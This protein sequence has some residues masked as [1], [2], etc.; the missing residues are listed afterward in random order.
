MKVLITGGMGFIGSYLTEKY[1]KTGHSVYI[2]DD[3]STGSRKNIEYLEKENKYSELLFLYE[4]TILNEK[5]ILELIGTC[6][7]VI[8]LAAAVGVKYILDN[9]LD[10][11]TTNI[12]GTEII[13]KYC[14]KFKKKLFLASTSEVYGKHV[15]APLLETDDSVYGPSTKSRWSYAASKLVDEFTALAYF[16]TK[17]L[18]VTIGRLFNTVGPRQTGRYGMVIPRFFNQAINNELLTIYGDGKQ[19]RTFTHVDDI[20]DAIIKLMDEDKSYGQV[21][22]IGGT[23]EI[24]IEDLAEKIIKITNSKSKIKFIPYSDVYKSKDFEDMQRRVPSIDKI[25]SQIDWNPTKNTDEILNSIF[26]SLN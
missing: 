19:S 17:G 9:P 13:L 18:Q 2:V 11:I 20:T 26:D 16:S 25:K 15:H 14:D 7:L 22:N 21:F 10:S 8:H 6:D 12:Q 4:D 3:L 23:E 1:L 24:T 5:I